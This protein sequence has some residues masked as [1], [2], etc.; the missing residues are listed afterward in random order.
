MGLNTGDLAGL[1][2]G[3]LA[4]LN[5]GDLTGMNIPAAIK[6]C[7]T[8]SFLDKFGVIFSSPCPTCRGVNIV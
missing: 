2:T 8:A 6:S 3:D 4:G 5:T 1:N 7:S